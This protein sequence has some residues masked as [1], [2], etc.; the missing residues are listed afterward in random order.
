[1]KK[2]NKISSAINDITF[3]KGDSKSNS[4]WNKITFENI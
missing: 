2:I 1:M 3:N 4:R